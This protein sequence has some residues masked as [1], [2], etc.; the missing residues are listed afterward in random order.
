MFR[1]LCSRLI[2]V[3]ISFLSL[4]KTGRNFS[5]RLMCV[6]VGFR[7]TPQEEVAIRAKLQVVILTIGGLG[8]ATA[9][10]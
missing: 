10:T 3:K 6:S 9:V 7:R 4:V 5:V 2:C 1:K 8:A